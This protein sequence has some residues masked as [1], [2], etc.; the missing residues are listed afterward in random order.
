MST[1]PPLEPDTKDWSWVLDE[2]LRSLLDQDTPTFATWDQDETAVAQCY[3]RQD[4]TDVVPALVAAA[5]QVA[6]TYDVVHH[7]GDLRPAGARDPR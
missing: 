5:R 3:D 2:R 6:V 1:S 4:L 7:L